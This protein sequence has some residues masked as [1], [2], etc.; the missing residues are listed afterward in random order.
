MLVGVWGVCW[1]G[2][3]VGFVLVVV[4][5]WGVGMWMRG[6]LWVVVPVTL[7]KP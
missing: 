1:V 4:L 5:R 2:W 3:E 7:S 6:G